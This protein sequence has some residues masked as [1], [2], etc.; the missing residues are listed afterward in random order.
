MPRA[1]FYHLAPQA[2]SR[3]LRIATKH[4]AA[5][6]IEGVSLNEILA[7]AGISK[8]AYYYYF[9]DK[10]DLLATVVEDT[11]ETMLR[12]ISMPAF[13]GLSREDFW[14]TVERFVASW[15][16]AVD[17]PADLLTVA[18]QFTSARRTSERFAPILAKAQGIYRAVIEPGQRLGCVRN[19]LPMDLL[20]QLLEANDAVLDRI[21][22]SLH[23][24]A[25]RRDVEQH[26]R[27]VFDT[28]RRLLV[29]EGSEPRRATGGRQAR[30]GALAPPA[31]R[32][33]R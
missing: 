13:D 9:D 12:R 15:T 23:A 6:G 31:Q 10:E 21:F 20:V 22:F 11:I 18:A 7:E 5:R 14:P 25:T 8:G 17:M 1:R 4:F 33:G 19:D 24:K 30:A 16:A 28:F 27:L 26:T 32:R 2:R 3:L 29:A